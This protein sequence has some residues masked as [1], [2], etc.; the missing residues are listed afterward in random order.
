MDPRISDPYLMLPKD[1]PPVQLEIDAPSC[2]FVFGN[3]GPPTPGNHLDNDKSA[4]GEHQSVKTEPSRA[5]LQGT[6]RTQKR[7]HVNFYITLKL[8]PNQTEVR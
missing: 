4:Q 8:F 3:V 2:T 1:S 5:N 6:D 7:P